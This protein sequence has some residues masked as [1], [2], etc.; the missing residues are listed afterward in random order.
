VRARFAGGSRLQFRPCVVLASYYAYVMKVEEN[1][2][3]VDGCLEYVLTESGAHR[4]P[5][6]APFPDAGAP[7]SRRGSPVRQSTT[8]QCHVSASA[9]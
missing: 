2:A 7:V 4:P 5:G 3:A 8:M 1:R 9:T 6:H